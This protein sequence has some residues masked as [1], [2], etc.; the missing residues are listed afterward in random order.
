MLGLCFVVRLVHEDSPRHSEAVL[1]DGPIRKVL[2]LKT[3][4]D[5]ST[6]YTAST[7]QQ[8]KII[9]HRGLRIGA[10][11]CM[12]AAE[13]CKGDRD[14]QETRHAELLKEFRQYAETTLL[15]V[16][17]RFEANGSAEVAKDWNQK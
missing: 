2:S 12:D 3:L 9:L 1:I 13:G 10:L 6:C 15:C 11:I 4:C 14:K 7:Q 16:P 17:A 5:K 8:D